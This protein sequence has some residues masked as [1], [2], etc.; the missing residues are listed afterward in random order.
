MRLAESLRDDGFETWTPIEERRIRIPRA[1]VR[2]S[3]KLP[4]MP[5]YIF[6]RA[7]HLVDLLQMANMPFKPRRSRGQP[8]HVDFSVMH[9][10]DTYPLI[11][12]KQLQALRQLE[13]KRTPRARAHK[14]F[15]ANVEV[16]VKVEG[17]SFA[18]M[19]GVVRRSDFG[20]TLVCFD[21]RLEVKI[22]TSLLF[23]DEVSSDQPAA[24]KAA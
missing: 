1:N 11:G 17:G 10:H 23:E 8:A 13:A 9:Y 16:R 21:K 14:V 22:P 5:S 6:A 2:R 7:H 20:H 3:V 19:R 24:T 18:G 4:I 12:E 15:G